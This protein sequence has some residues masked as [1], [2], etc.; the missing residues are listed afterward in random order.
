MTAENLSVALLPNPPTTMA[1]VSVAAS[2][3]L[4]F[5]PPHTA[6]NGAQARL[7]YPPPM[8]M[9]PTLEPLAP[10]VQ[11]LPKMVWV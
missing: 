2:P 1:D 10:V 3:A 8:A 11:E 6:V 4:L 5:L 9:L 7:P